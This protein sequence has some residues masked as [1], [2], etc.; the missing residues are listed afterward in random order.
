MPSIARSAL[1]SHSASEMYRLVHDVEAYPDFLPWCQSATV[2]EQDERSQLATLTI[3][4]RMK[5]LRFTTRNTLVENES[6]HMALVDGPFRQ[7]KGEWRFKA[8][9]DD[10]CRVELQID[11][12]FKSRVFATLMGP[13]FSRIC[14]TMV[15]AFVN[16]ANQIHPA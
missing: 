2:T 1:V 7:L 12:E 13:A 9:D 5:G 4:K 11:F 10:A 3:D 6:I 8:I 16:R 15:A 14:D